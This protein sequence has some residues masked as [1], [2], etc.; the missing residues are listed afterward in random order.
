MTVC[1]SDAASLRKVDGVTIVFEMMVLGIWR[2]PDVA[3]T[4]TGWCCNDAAML[5]RFQCCDA[6]SM[7]GCCILW[8]MPTMLW[9]CRDDDWCCI[10]DWMPHWWLMFSAAIMQSL[11]VLAPF[12]PSLFHFHFTSPVSPLPCRLLAIWLQVFTVH[13]LFYS[14]FFGHTK[15]QLNQSWAISWF[16]LWL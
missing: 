16:F 6:A 10:D 7:I 4:I 5:S 2:R 15:L 13:F 3:A 12:K 1:C 8:L 9:C 11:L 14:F